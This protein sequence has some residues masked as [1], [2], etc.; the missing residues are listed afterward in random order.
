MKYLV[1]AIKDTA[2]GSFSPPFYQQTHGLA[3][4]AF[5][6]A[7]NDPQSSINRHPHDYHLFH[8]GNWDTESGLFTSLP[9][10]EH[11][12]DAM[13]VLAKRDLSPQQ[14]ISQ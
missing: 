6:D 14:L 12:Q 11:M 1:Y 8:L 9:A 5:K 7:A 2:S 4:R 3:E 10:P 13:S